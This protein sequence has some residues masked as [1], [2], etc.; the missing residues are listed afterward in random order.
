MAAT[1]LV[2]F[3]LAIVLF[4]LWAVRGSFHRASAAR[5]SRGF[6]AVDTSAFRNLLSNDDDHYLQSSLSPSA[7]RKARRARLRAVQEY[8]LRMAEDCAAILEMLRLAN[9]DVP[10]PLAGILVRRAIRI[11]V[12]SLG[13]WF[14]L[15][16]E[17]LFPGLE[18]NP[19]R[20]L[21]VYEEFRRRAEA[22]M[23]QSSQ[24]GSLA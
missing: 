14:L 20:I 11:R 6:H 18:L 10:S 17:W 23:R 22:S 16:T 5:G 7:Y 21:R 4:V 24:E 19:I 1:V 15:W 3:S 8:L 9:T 2:F 12:I 13:F